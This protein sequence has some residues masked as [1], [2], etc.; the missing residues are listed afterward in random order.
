MFVFQDKEGQ[1]PPFRLIVS[2]NRLCETG[3]NA[4][5]RND[6]QASPRNPFP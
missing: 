3:R 1:S 4:T 6:A 5:R 2:H